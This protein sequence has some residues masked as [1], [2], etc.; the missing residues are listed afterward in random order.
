MSWRHVLQQS[1]GITVNLID[2]TAELLFLRDPDISLGYI[3]PGQ[4]VPLD[5]FY[6]VQDISP[7]HHNHLRSNVNVYYIDRCR[8]VMTAG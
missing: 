4:S 3:P 5:K 8:S 2:I 7:F 1:V 6:M